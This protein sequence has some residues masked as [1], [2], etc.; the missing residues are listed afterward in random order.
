M[1][2]IASALPAQPFSNLESPVMRLRDLIFGL[3]VASPEASELVDRLDP[4]IADELHAIAAHRRIAAADFVAQA[5]MELALDNADAIWSAAVMQRAGLRGNAEAVELGNILVRAMRRHL[6][7][8]VA[9]TCGE[10]EQEVAFRHYR[11]GHSYVPD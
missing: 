10:T 7:A 1:S 2:P 8:E 11:V 4:A 9:I 5:L 3:H 6:W